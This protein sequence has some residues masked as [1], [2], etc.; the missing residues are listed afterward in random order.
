MNRMRQDLKIWKTIFR[1]K[2]LSYCKMKTQNKTV[3]EIIKQYLVENEYDG[4]YN[5]DIDC[6]CEL[7]DLA[8]CGQ[9]MAECTSGYKH[10]LGDYDF[11][12]KED[13]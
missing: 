7:S 10:K 2:S 4:L 3:I 1:F 5:E 6:A 8:P 13:R 9:T 12:I 11:T